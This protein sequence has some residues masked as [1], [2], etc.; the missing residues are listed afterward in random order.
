MIA[1][2]G[3]ENETIIQPIHFIE[4]FR[5][6][7]D[8]VWGGWTRRLNQDGTYSMA[9]FNQGMLVK[10][11]FYSTRNESVLIKNGYIHFEWG[12]VRN[13]LF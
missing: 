8:I 1:G 11:E 3:I 12:I 13:N 6:N 10:G 4:W 9:S 7:A 2:T 5:L